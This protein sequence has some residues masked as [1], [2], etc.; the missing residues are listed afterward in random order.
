MQALQGIEA[1]I[2]CNSR[3]GR[4]HAATVQGL[5]HQGRFY[6]LLPAYE[7]DELSRYSP[8]NLLLRHLFDWCL[9][10]NIDVFNFTAGDESYKTEW[11]DQTMDL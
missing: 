8:G 2:I 3:T 10:R 7:N 9:A 6:Y 11:S 1:G 4:E 5:A